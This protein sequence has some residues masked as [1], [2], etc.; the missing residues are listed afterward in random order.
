LAANKVIGK[1]FLFYL[2]NF[3]T[4]VTRL[5]LKSVEGLHEDGESG[6]GEMNHKCT[7]HPCCTPFSIPFYTWIIYVPRT[8]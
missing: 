3:L 8:I 7:N 6:D 2:F 5:R 1:L 4:I